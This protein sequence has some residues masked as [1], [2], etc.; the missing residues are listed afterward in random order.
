M[1]I[2]SAGEDLLKERPH[3]TG[4]PFTI[5]GGNLPSGE[6]QMVAVDFDEKLDCLWIVGEANKKII[7][8]DPETGNVIAHF[9]YPTDSIVSDGSRVQKAIALACFY[10][11]AES[12]VYLLCRNGA[13]QLQLYKLKA[14]TDTGQEELIQE[15]YF[16][17]QE[18]DLVTWGDKTGLAVRGF[19]IYALGGLDGEKIYKL[20]DIGQV[21]EEYLILEG[22]QGLCALNGC[23]YTGNIESTSNIGYLDKYTSLEPMV[24][25]RFSGQEPFVFGNFSGD[26]CSNTKEMW[27]VNNEK[28]YVFNMKHYT[29][30][31][32][33]KPTLDINL[34]VIQTTDEKIIEVKFKNIAD[35]NA[36]DQITITIPTDPNTDAD[37]MIEL[38]I[39]NQQTWGKSISY[40][41]PLGIS[42]EFIF[43]IKG[44]VPAEA[45]NALNPR[46]A[47]LQVAYKLI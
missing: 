41:S 23:F 10:E 27:V 37:D 42:G 38:S 19:D 30:I 31:V 6:N 32:D 11:N 14:S 7:R 40:G 12:Y 36:M 5:T 9:E 24:N 18:D 46:V 43:H 21:L 26:I 47:T 16:V 13:N 44:S 4:K 33:E 22:S 1:S 8:V 45:N 15:N 17:I 25:D 20:N 34:D 3:R 2:I 35:R 29:Y 28:V 39:D